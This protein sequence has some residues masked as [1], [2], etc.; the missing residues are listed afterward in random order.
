MRILVACFFNL[1]LAC[2]AA[3]EDQTF[4]FATRNYDVEMTVRFPEN[5]LGTKLSFYDTTR[6]RETCLAA[7]GMDTGCID[8]FVGALAVVNFSVKRRNNGSPAGAILREEVITVE[9]APGLPP[10]PPFIKSQRLVRG[11]ASDI[12]LFGYDEGALDP[13]EREQARRDWTRSAYQ[14]CRQE[15]FLDDDRAPF[16]VV[17]WKHFMNRI[18]LVRVQGGGGGR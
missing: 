10:R 11:L 16:A 8:R 7:D 4:R 15:L 2:A 12:Q 3:A 18:V 14:S 6:R 13:A 1:A 5:Y 9:R 17:E